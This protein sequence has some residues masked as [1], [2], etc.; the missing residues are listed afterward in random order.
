MFI[1]EHKK[2]KKKTQ[3]IHLI[4]TTVWIVTQVQVLTLVL[5]NTNTEGLPT[6]Q[7][8]STTSY[9][10][11]YCKVAWYAYL[12]SQIGGCSRATMCTNTPLEQ[13]TSVSY[14]AYSQLY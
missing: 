4:R 8:V 3:V 2:V 5:L 6:Y 10:H 11:L 12:Y 14:F 9:Q 7:W 13:H 1:V